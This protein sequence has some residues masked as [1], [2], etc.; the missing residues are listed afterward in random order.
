MLMDYVE[1]VRRA[2][3]AFASAIASSDWSQINPYFSLDYVHEVDAQSNRGR[4][5]GVHVGVDAYIHFLED[6]TTA[7]EFESKEVE[8]RLT[9]GELDDSLARIYQVVVLETVSTREGSFTNRTY[10]RIED[11]R[12]IETLSYISNPQLTDRVYPAH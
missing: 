3:N 1:F 2:R 4:L 7:A 12:I 9:V 10:F 8:T 6:L 5:D 11:G